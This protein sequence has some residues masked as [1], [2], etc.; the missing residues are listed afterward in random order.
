[1]SPC[2][3]RATGETIQ[4]APSTLQTP[5]ADG[6]NGVAG[7]HFIIDPFLM[8]EEAEREPVTWQHLQLSGCVRSEF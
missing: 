6:K 4:W 8:G 3:V 1:M 5:L 2:N 7:V